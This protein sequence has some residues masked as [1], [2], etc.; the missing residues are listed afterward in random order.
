[1]QERRKAFEEELKAAEEK[2]MQALL[3]FFKKDRQGGV[4][5]IQGAVL[6]SIECKSIKIP[7]IK[8]NNNPPPVTSSALSGEEVTHM[9][10]HTVSASLA[11]RLQK[12]IDGSIDNWLESSLDSMVHSAM[13]RVNDETAKK[14]IEFAEPN[15]TPIKPSF[16][17]INSQD[18]RNYS[19]SAEINS[20]LGA[21]NQAGTSGAT[22]S[23][24]PSQSTYAYSAPYFKPNSSSAQDP[25]QYS[26]E[27]VHE[28]L[29]KMLCEHCG[30]EPTVRTRGYHKPY[31]EIYDSYRYPPGF[32]VPEFVKFTKEDNRIT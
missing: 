26:V 12:M 1:L 25:P 13:L 11:I 10:D 27:L 9:V 3:W 7:E 8:L 19:N 5:Q 16:F 2:E 31:P 21:P 14:Q 15:A 30:I 6:P 24:P 23:A 22:T 28:Q 20:I 29:S 18:C 32:I 4:T 17:Y